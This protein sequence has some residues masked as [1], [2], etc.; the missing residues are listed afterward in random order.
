MAKSGSRRGRQVKARPRKASGQARK[1]TTPKSKSTKRA[2]VGTPRAC[3]SVASRGGHSW[4]STEVG[5]L[6]RLARGN[7]PTRL[8]AWKL[9]RSESAVRSKASTL[10]VSLKPVN[11]SPYG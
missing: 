9:G 10:K 1:S 6:R 5:A 4:S 11:Q 8:L 3:R 7:T 2:S